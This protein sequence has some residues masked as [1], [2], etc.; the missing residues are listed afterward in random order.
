MSINAVVMTCLESWVVDAINSVNNQ[1]TPFDGKHLLVDERFLNDEGKAFLDSI[2]DSLDGWSIHIH[3]VDDNFSIHKNWMLDQLPKNEEW[4]LW[5]D[6]DEVI[7]NRF[8]STAISMIEFSDAY[9]ESKVDAYA[10][11]FV[12]SFEGREG[13]LVLDWLNPGTW[14]YPDWHVRFF[15]NYKHT[16]FVGLVHEILRGWKTLVPTSDPKMTILHRKT[17]AMQ[18]ISNRRWRRL[19]VLR[20]QAD[21]TYR[22]ELQ[23]EEW[24]NFANQYEKLV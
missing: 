6:A 23:G 7:N 4:I 24:T 3:S 5:L 16:Y 9:S 17:M 22:L 18:D 19:D 12:H 21:P 1:E 11:A 8:V 14:L 15:K 10:L 20:R 2:Q 13:E